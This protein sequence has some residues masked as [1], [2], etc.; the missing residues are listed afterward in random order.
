MAVVP[1]KQPGPEIRD[2]ESQLGHAQQL[3][4]REVL[5]QKNQLNAATNTLALLC[6][7]TNAL[8]EAA[9]TTCRFC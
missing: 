6:Q 2:V 9:G 1:G 4:T 8:E 7:R 5:G 3:T